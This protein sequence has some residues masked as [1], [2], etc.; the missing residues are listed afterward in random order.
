MPKF[1]NR[2]RTIYKRTRAVLLLLFIVT[3]II[4]IGKSITSSKITHLQSSYGTLIK[5]KAGIDSERPDKSLLQS[6]DKGE[7]VIRIQTRLKMYGYNV[8]IDGDYG[9]RTVYA[10][11]DFQQRRNLE[12][13]GTVSGKTLDALYRT[14]KKDN[15]YK[16][17][18]KLLLNSNVSSKAAYESIVNSVEST[19]YTNNY[20]LVNLSEQKVYIFYGTNHNWKL[21]NI[22]TCASG[23]VTTPTVTGHFFIGIKG[24]Y[25]KSGIS[26][27]CKYFSQI[28]GN[29][30]FHSILYDKNGNILDGN[31]GA[32]ASHGCIRLALINA[33][34]IYDNIPIGSGIWVK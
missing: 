23:R 16:P 1:E 32:V 13:S 4:I 12:I 25:F 34:Y 6:G 20:I 22:F 31:L 18:T 28:S 17:V 19:S 26:V 9:D 3:G 24:L 30:L 33:K 7:N 14:P 21:I 11:M 27:Y 2:A 5:S 29:Y 10:V 8:I 15:V